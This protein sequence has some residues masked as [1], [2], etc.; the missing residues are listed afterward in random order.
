MKLTLKILATLA[1]TV[2]LVGCQ[3][4]PGTHSDP[5]TGTD[6][7]YSSSYP[8]KDSLLSTLTTKV[9]WTNK[10]GYVIDT[11]FMGTGTG[12]AFFSEAWSHGTKLT[13]EKVD[14]QLLSCSSGCTITETGAIHLTDAQF[15]SGLE[16]GFEFKLVGQ[17][18][19]IVGEIPARLFREVSEQMGSS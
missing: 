5:H 1:L 12:W 4:E 9:A 14:S 16:S 19:S 6:V 7:V 2:S 8:A 15:N 10:D 17:R 3:T 11:K 13:F 18:T